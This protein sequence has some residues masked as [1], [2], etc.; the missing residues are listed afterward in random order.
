MEIPYIFVQTLG[1]GLLVYSM[2]GFHW[3]AA[4]FFW[5]LFFMYLT[6]L[7]MTY[8]GMMTVAMTP[9]PTIAAIVAASFYGI[10]NLFSGFVIP[11]TVSSANHIR[12]CLKLEI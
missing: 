8:Y 5:Y 3:T 7:Y 4:K 9:N 12:L 11:R 1:Y 6:L 2:I 10:W